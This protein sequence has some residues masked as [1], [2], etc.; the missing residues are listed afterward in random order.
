LQCI[1]GIAKTTIEN[2]VNNINKSCKHGRPTLFTTI[3]ETFLVDY[4]KTLVRWGFPLNKDAVKNLACE[5]ATVND[6]EFN[7]KKWQPGEDWLKVFRKRNNDA[8]GYRLKNT[9]SKQRACSLNEKSLSNFYDIVEEEL[10][11]LDLTNR[12]QNFLSHYVIFKGKLIQYS[13]RFKH[14]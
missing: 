7:G 11:R 14:Y 1:V 9:I 12:P 6:I 2:H 8:L 10:V 13:L 5:Y 4:I 3:Q